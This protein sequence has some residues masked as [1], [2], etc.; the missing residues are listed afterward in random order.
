ML[1][2]LLV[3]WVGFKFQR[4]LSEKGCLNFSV[5]QVRGLLRQ[6]SLPHFLTFTVFSR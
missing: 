4:T 6:Y 2:T 1:A 5:I 3:C